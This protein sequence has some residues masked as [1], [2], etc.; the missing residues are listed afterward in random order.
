MTYLESVLYIH[1]ETFQYDSSLQENEF[2]TFITQVDISDFLKDPQ[3]YKVYAGHIL[4]SCSQENFHY[5]LQEA[6]KYN[7]SLSFLPDT[8]QKEFINLYRLT[9]DHKTNLE[10]AL[11]DE[12]YH[13]LLKGDSSHTTVEN[14][15]FEHGFFHMGRF[16]QQYQDMYGKLPSHT[17]KL[18]T[19]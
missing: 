17:F 6:V 4:V 2:G 14:I 1:D 5:I 7:Y 8:K 16:S 13:S 15:A 10:I 3:S 18:E 12:L 9:T 11:R 19:L